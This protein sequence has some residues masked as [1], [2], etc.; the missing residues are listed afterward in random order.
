MKVFKVEGFIISIEDNLFNKAV[1]ALILDRGD[2]Y[3][4]EYDNYIYIKNALRA[5]SCKNKDEFA[6][7]S[8]DVLRKR[9]TD[10]EASENV[11]NILKQHIYSQTN[12]I[13]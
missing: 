12:R 1:E 4:E 13:I 8:Y 7:F 5:G 6:S 3:E 11:K 9:L 10:E 2:D